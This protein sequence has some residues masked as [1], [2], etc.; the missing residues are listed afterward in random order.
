MKQYL[1]RPDARKGI[2]GEPSLPDRLRLMQS[3]LAY[4]S[5]S[6]IAAVLFPGLSY[7][8][9]LRLRRKEA[10]FLL[11]VRP[12]I[13][14]AF[15]LLAFLGWFVYGMLAA[16]GGGDAGAINRSFLMRYS[17]F[18][19]LLLLACY[20]VSV[21]CFARYLVF[22]RS[23]RHAPHPLRDGIVAAALLAAVFVNAFII[24]N[25]PPVAWT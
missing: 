17:L 9:Y 21:T 2:V 11:L 19:C 14:E 24:V 18:Q 3:R 6:I 16:I 1:E 25:L 5:V 4:V 13:Y 22:V 23:F 15:L 20:A 8:L 7:F 12:I 10:R